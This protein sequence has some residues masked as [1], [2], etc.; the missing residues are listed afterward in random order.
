M[1]VETSLLAEHCCSVTQQRVSLAVSLLRLRRWG[2]FVLKSTKWPLIPIPML[3]EL[4]ALSGYSEEQD[5]LGWKWC[6]PPVQHNA[7]AMKLCI[8]KFCF[9]PAWENCTPSF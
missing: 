7:C 1:A 4:P 9:S 3:Q 8:K 6:R 5:T 2:S